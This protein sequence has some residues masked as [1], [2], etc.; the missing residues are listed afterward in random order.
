MKVTTELHVTLE[1]TAEEAKWLNRVMQNPLSDDY[2]PESEGSYDKKM[3]EAF[4]EATT[5]EDYWGHG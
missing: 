1:L 2:D 5:S 4:F 3:R